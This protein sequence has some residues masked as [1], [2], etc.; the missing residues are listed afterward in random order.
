M[1]SPELKFKL[2]SPQAKLPQYAHEGDAGFDLFSAETVTL[3][4]GQRHVF[5]IGIASEIPLGY[6]VS[7]RDKSGLAV[8][9]GLHVLGGV[10][11]SGY[12][13]EWGVVLV[14][15]GDTECTV[16]KVDKVAQGILQKAPRAEIVI[17][18]ELSA[19]ARGGGG[20]GSTGK[21]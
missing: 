21:N 15:L 4:P 5:R 11:D 19:T 13:G 20:F 12:R 7:I 18:D 3:A 2:L 9:K 8:N 10:I 14:N 16:E 1:A 17:T 6:F